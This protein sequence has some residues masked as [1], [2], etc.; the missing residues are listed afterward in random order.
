ML[1]IN[2]RKRDK[3]PLLIPGYKLGS[4]V[5]STKECCTL[6]GS[7]FE[8]MTEHVMVGGEEFTT[9]SAVECCPDVV[10]TDAMEMVESKASN[11]GSQLKIAH[12]QIDDYMQARA[13]GWKVSYAFWMYGEKQLV[14][15]FKTYHKIIKA[16]VGSVQYLDILDITIVDAIRRYEIT[17]DMEL[18][19]DNDKLPGVRTILN[20]SQAER[21][22]YGPI[23]MT[24]LSK[25]FFAW[26]RGDPDTALA[27][28][29]LKGDFDYQ[30]E[31]KIVV[32]A[33]YNGVNFDSG[34]FVCWKIEPICDVPF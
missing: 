13:E 25:K 27:T 19:D 21:D 1:I 3:S 28:L 30:A 6:T 9:N 14:K 17:E 16:V 24:L 20:W 5:H 15:R 29:G 12:H 23:P 10:N 8:S 32:R 26:L 18:R 11:I 31:G 7:I 22:R 2:K 4:E 33:D 34:S